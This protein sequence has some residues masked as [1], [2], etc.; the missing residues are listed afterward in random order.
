[1]DKATYPDQLSDAANKSFDKRLP[2]DVSPVSP[3]FLGNLVVR[4]GSVDLLEEG[5]E[6]RSFGKAGRSGPRFKVF[7]GLVRM[8][9]YF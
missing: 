9:N 1:M 5:W 4:H 6:C 8:W 7:N 2:Q 3:L